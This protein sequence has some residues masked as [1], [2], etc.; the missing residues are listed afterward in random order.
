M[1]RWTPGGIAC[2]LSLNFGETH[3]GKLPSRRL[4]HRVPGNNI[5]TGEQPEGQ[6]AHQEPYPALRAKAL[7]SLLVSKGLV[8]TD[9]IDVMVQA[10]KQDIGAYIR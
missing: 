7:E 1:P 9:V 6:H 8:P 10:Y 5:T 4:A 3:V 2:I